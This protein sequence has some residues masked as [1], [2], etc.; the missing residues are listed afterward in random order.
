MDELD[1]YLYLSQYTYA[2]EKRRKS[3]LGWAYPTKMQYFVQPKGV[4]FGFW[5]AHIRSCASLYRNN[6]KKIKLNIWTTK[7]KY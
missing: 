2:I 7:I 5:V 6:R 1:E 4:I 3:A